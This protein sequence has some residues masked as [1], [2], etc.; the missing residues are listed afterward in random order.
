MGISINCLNH[1]THKIYTTQPP[2][3]FGAADFRVTFAHKRTI[4]RNFKTREEHPISVL[5]VPQ[6]AY[7]EY[8][9]RKRKCTVTEIHKHGLKWY[10]HTLQELHLPKTIKYIDPR[11]TLSCKKLQTI[12]I[13]AGNPHYKVI[14]GIVY[15]TS[16]GHLSLCI[17]PQ[18][19]Q[20]GTF[21]VA[22][23]IDNVGIALC[24]QNNLTR[25]E[26]AEGNPHYTAIDGVLYNKAK[27]ILLCYPAG[28]RADTFI[29]PKSVDSIAPYAFRYTRLRRLVIDNNVTM[30]SPNA[31]SSARIDTL[32]L[33]ESI[34]VLEP[35]ALKD[36]KIKILEILNENISST[37]QAI[38]DSAQ[39][40]YKTRLM[41]ADKFNRATDPGYQIRWW[42]W[43]Q[44]L[45]WGVFIW[46]VQYGLKGQY[47]KRA[48][49]FAPC[50]A[51]EE[52][53]KRGLR[54]VALNVFL[55]ALLFALNILLIDYV[56][57]NRY[58][59]GMYRSDF[60]PFTFNL[61][62]V[63]IPS[64]M[65]INALHALRGYTKS[66]NPDLTAEQA[67]DYIFQ[68]LGDATLDSEGEWD[69][70]KIYCTIP[71]KARKA[72]W[73]LRLLNFVGELL[74]IAIIIFS[75]TITIG[76]SGIDV[77]DSYDVCFPIYWLSYKC[78]IP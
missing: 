10:E 15:Q 73:Y 17:I 28:K 32:V 34:A 44:V 11:L 68:V 43:C 20:I 51:L 41:S 21:T 18:A 49:F 19:K 62:L 24:G 77:F 37:E 50:H 63:L 30:L 31:F 55:A 33:G 40:I 70:P 60:W 9:Y 26:V 48:P 76:Y 59:I 12:R 54:L 42:L 53:E 65:A 38:P 6:V 39:V 78:L 7:N 25:I 14:N 72:P 36:S 69:F 61:I 29:V 2:P 1:Q 35:E 16:N 23:N 56:Y 57:H 64:Y 8:N 45:L 71:M 4:Y 27:N 3:H 22:A 46:A 5:T 13:A 52:D 66:F 67:E 58:G 47:R 75:I 74:T